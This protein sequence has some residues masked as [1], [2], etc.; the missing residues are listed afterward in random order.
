MSASIR[1]P[2]A[3]FSD[4]GRT[5]AR[6]TRAEV[7]ILAGFAAARVVLHLLTNGRYGYFRD[8]FYYLACADHLAWGYVDH[9]PLSIGVLA[10]TRAVLGTSIQAIRLPVVLAGGATVAL[11]GLTARAMGGGRFAQAL[12]CLTV[13]AAP[14]FLAMGTFFSMNAFDQLF[15]TLG[16]YL[17]VRIIT[18]GNPRLWLWFGVV[19]GLG[20]LNKISMAFFGFGIVV[21]LLAT[22]QRRRF[23]SGHLW[24]GGLIALLLFL[25]HVGWQIRHGWPTL[26]FIHHATQHKITVSSP[27]AFLGAQG[28]LLS[29]LS[30]PIW[31]AGIVYG[32]IGR[33]GRRFAV[34]S[35]AYLV[36]LGLFL[37]TNAKT[38]YLSPAYPMLLALGAVWLARVTAARRWIRP[39]A[40]GVLL[41]GGAALVPMGLPI[42]DPQ[43]YPRYES[44]LGLAPPVEERGPVGPLP[45]HFADR[46]GWQEFVDT[47]A[48][49]YHALDEPDRR[50]CAVVTSNY[51]EAGA[52]DLLGPAR[53][54]PPAVCP[55]NNYFLWGPR[56][57]TGDVALA[58]I[59]DSRMPWLE[60]QFD[61]VTE[62]ARFRH[63]LVMPYQDD[64]PLC[65]CRGLKT[66]VEQFWQSIRSFH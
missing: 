18:T 11:A 9:P 13:L 34:L 17:L 6:L 55:Y 20:L 29:P 42:L 47:V 28:L 65:L 56:R 54:L 36:V 3:L 30:A 59:H 16:A 62:V 24:L 44:A 49:A 32:L 5:A 19:A 23:A 45:Q 21:G 4:A 26:E 61:E 35:V 52:I 37:V 40:F 41:A 10:L 22:R 43:T 33:D 31:V 1:E 7:L 57:F 66:P 38:Y 14:V 58:C 50:R 53:G 64:R 51:G 27:L 63:P 8:E 25:P 2:K 12:A 39:V 15:W 48:G 46:F 60:E